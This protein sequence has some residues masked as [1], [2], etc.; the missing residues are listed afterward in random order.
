M[1]SPIQSLL[2]TPRS[3]LRRLLADLPLSIAVSAVLAI[4]ISLVSG[5]FLENFLV[6]ILIGI[7]AFSI[8]NGGRLLWWDRPHWGVR[9]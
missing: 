3:R 1:S 8:V 4:F 6:S 9:E 7:V 5:Q 2:P